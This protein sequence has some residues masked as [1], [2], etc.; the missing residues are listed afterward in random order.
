MQ[1]EFNLENKSESDV[2]LDQMQ[3]QIDTAVESM[4]KVRRKLFSEMGEL[5]KIMA[6]L[7]VENETLKTQV[8]EL[9]NEKIEWQY[10]KTD[11]LFDVREPAV[12]FG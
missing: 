7:K 4:G 12:A 10:Q 3:K 11:C 9:K 5:K 2:K 1:L 8:R 6:E